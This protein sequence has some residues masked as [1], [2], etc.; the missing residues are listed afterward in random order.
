MPFVK[1]VT[2]LGKNQMPKTFM[3]KFNK[4]LAAIF[5][6]QEVAFKWQLET[7]KYMAVVRK[8]SMRKNVLL[9]LF[10]CVSAASYL[11]Q[12]QPRPNSY[13]I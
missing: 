12:L 7:D 8:C 1:V 13:V 5:D 2:N 10:H 9:R 4:E 3:P 11:V 6:K